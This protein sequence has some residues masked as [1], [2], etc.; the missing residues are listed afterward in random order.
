M[1][2]Q[3]IRKE[4]NNYFSLWYFERYM[5]TT[6]TLFFKE[7]LTKG[8][9]WETTSHGNKILYSVTDKRDTLLLGTL[10]K[11]V[12][13]I[14]GDIYFEEKP[15]LT[16]YH[17]YAEGIGEIYNF[18]PSPESRRYVDVELNLLKHSQE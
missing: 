11:N 4:G 3:L 15:W 8:E 12:V 16:T 1:E 6:E 5:A 17:G 18:K 9:Q 13:M 2:N 7:H 14:R 10:Y